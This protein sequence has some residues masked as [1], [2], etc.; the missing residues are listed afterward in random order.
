MGI[1]RTEDELRREICEIGRRIHQLGFVAGFDGNISARLDSH[2]I[3]S[4]PTTISKGM[5]QADD[6][7][8][9]DYDGK[10]I[11]GRRNVTSEIAMHLLI[12]RRRRDAQAVVHAHPPTATGYA[13]A[14]MSLN[15]ALISEVV[16]TLG[17]IPLARYG[18]PGTAELTAAL[19]PLVGTHDAILMANHGVVTFAPDLE[20]AYFKMETVEHF[21]KI[22][23]VTELLGKQ[24]LLSEAEVDKLLAA[25]QRYFGPGT[26]AIE[27]TDVCPVAD[28]GNRPADRNPPE[29]GSVAVSRQDLEAMVNRTVRNLK[30]RM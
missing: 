7:V 14:G 28:T 24:V 21:A 27:R 2:R 26:P 1:T 20:R 11:S 17:C 13:A 8:I 19:E 12:Y 3:L 4:S 29:A 23:L 22:S 30:S 6:L 10:K 18:T 5:M 16:L 15:K 9:C 25:R